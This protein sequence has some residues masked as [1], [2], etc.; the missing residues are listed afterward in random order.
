MDKKE[1]TGSNIVTVGD[2]N[3]ALTSMDRS[4]RQR[5][6]KEM[7]ALNDILDQMDLID[8]LRAFHLKQ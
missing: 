7:E 8:I 2:F 4:S 5:I 1:E 6:N 3:T